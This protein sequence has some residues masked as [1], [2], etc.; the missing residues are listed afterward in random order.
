V[1]RTKY[2]EQVK[3]CTH[4]FATR[5]IFVQ[6]KPGVQFEDTFN[7]S[8][9]F[10]LSEPGGYLFQVSRTIPKVN[11]KPIVSNSVLLTVMPKE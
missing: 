7:F 10:D 6:L 8:A 4:D 5:S 9:L 2:G 11:D 1:P 3:H